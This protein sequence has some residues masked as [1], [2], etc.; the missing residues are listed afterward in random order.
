MENVMPIKSDLETYLDEGVY[1]CEVNLESQFDVIGWWKANNL[2][3]K[4]LSKMS[5]DILSIPIT[6]V[7]SE[8]AFST[9]GR[10]IDPYRASLST[11]VV[12]SFD[13]WRRLDT[14]LVQ[15]KGRQNLYA[16]LQDPQLGIVAFTRMSHCVVAHPAADTTASAAPAVHAVAPSDL[17]S[18][19][20]YD[21]G[22]HA[23]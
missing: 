21:P 4:I 22:L 1:I 8:A 19:R 10:V 14:F 9:G 16:V 13:M 15:S 18:G 17:H 11:K 23:L 7:A 6:T 3:Y 12:E 5:V 20:A 2:K